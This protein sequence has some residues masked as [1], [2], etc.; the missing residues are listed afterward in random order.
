MEIEFDDKFRMKSA[1]G[2]GGGG[3]AEE[4]L[5][6]P[7]PTSASRRRVANGTP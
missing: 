5:P 2:G 4:V 6:H 1:V 3:G 7:A